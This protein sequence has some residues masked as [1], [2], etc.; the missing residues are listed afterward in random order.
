MLLKQDNIYYKRGE[1][2]TGIKES[3]RPTVATTLKLSAS[4]NPFFK[5]TTIE[6]AI[7]SNSQ[8]P[9][10]SVYDVSGR[11]VREFAIANKRGNIVWDGT[12]ASGIPL[13]AGIFYIELGGIDNEI[14]IKVILLR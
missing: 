5:E 4:P 9:Y 3:E 7:I 2:E 10:I 6:Y 11:K 14:S 8:S 13:P 1:N 12:N